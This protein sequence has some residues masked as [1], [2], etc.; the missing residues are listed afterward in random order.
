[1]GT[2]LWA[3]LQGLQLVLAHNLQALVIETDAEEVLHLLQSTNFTHSNILHDYRLLLQ[4][5]NS[6][7][8]SHTYREANGVADNLAKLGC[9][10]NFFDEVVILIH[11]PAFTPAGLA[12]DQQRKYQ[13]RIISSTTAIA[14]DSQQFLFSPH[15][16]FI[17]TIHRI[18]L[19]Y[20]PPIPVL[21]FS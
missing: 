8:I 5:H 4:Q 6:P 12:K 7:S 1:M 15:S 13:H 18:K 19:D 9:S 2:E 21:M 14:A 16:P 10:T 11:G 3:I 20:W 17:V